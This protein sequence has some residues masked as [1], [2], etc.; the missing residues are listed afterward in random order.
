MTIKKILEKLANETF[1]DGYKA[2]G[3][4]YGDD[5]YIPEV[6][7]AITEIAKLIEYEVIGLNVQGCE[8]HSGTAAPSEYCS[9]GKYLQS[10]GINN[11]LQTQ[12]NNLKRILQ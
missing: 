6:D 2:G 7:K 4:E 8:V 9:F 3:V 11:L 12:R 10:T 1:Y 5:G